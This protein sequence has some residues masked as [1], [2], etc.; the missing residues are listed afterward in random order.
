MNDNEINVTYDSNGKVVFA[1]DVVATIAALAAG[2]VEGVYA[3]N[4]T[5]IEGISE[6]FGKKVYTKGI[7]V[8]VG[9][10]ECAVD[11]NVILRYGYKV[12]EVANNIQSEV[13]NAIETMTGLRVVETN[14]YVDA[15]YFEPEKKRAEIPAAAPVQEAEPISVPEQEVVI[16]P[17]AVEISGS[18]SESEADST[19]EE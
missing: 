7:R 4:G 16:E 9:A 19:K 5:A 10:E 11:V 3:M 14:V 18:E 8:Q 1:E 2:D 15:V 12:I 17:E 6:R 13:K